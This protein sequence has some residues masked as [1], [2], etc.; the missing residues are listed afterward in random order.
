MAQQPESPERNLALE[1]VRVTE[2]A[3]LAAAR[4]MGRGDKE[5]GDQAAV[6]AMRL[7]LST[8]P[9]DGI[10]VIGE[11]EKD[12][13][14][15]LYNGEHIGNGEPPP[16]DVAVD[17]IDGTRLLA[18]G[19]ANALS[20]VALASH[21]SMFNPNPVVYMEKI[22]V[23]PEC[24]GVIDLAQPIE[25]NLSRIAEAKG[26]DLDDL[27]VVVLDRPRHEELVRRIRG[28]GA[29]IRL[30]TDGDVAGGIMAAIPQTGVD[31]LVGIG[32]S[33]EG[34]ISACA[35][36][37][38]GGEIQGRLWPRDERER[39]MARERGLDLERILSTDDLVNDENVFFAA[40][41]I[42]DGELLRGVRY[43]GEGATTHSLV[44]R[45]KSGTT[46]WVEASHR[47][48]KL[49]RYSAVAYD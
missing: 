22:V 12:E 26:K 10:V 7:M 20:V 44:T 43:S 17:P 24:R 27:T 21:G 1:L 14:P 5:A 42:T 23:G 37:C 25:A 39:D 16:V 40:T 30:I 48:D 18:Y 35:T 41:G 47:W 45:S 31:A 11:G 19:R 8:V 49:M 33:P 15:M 28:V 29:R 36:K 3:A 32:G 38:L 6:D 34:V 2:A 9:M 13:A 4:W 46:R